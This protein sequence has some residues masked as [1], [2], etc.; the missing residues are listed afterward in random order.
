MIGVSVTP[1]V[2]DFTQTG[3]DVLELSFG[4]QKASEDVLLDL[5][6]TDVARLKEDNLDSF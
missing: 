3:S 6:E 4:A 2:N 5:A 1:I